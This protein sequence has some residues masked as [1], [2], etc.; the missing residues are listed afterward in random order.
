MPG[1]F[2][3]LNGGQ[4]ADPFSSIPNPNTSEQIA[5][6]LADKQ[7]ALALVALLGNRFLAQQEELEER[8]G[9]TDSNP[10]YYSSALSSGDDL[11]AK[12][13]EWEA[14]NQEMWAQLGTHVSRVPLL[15]IRFVVAH[16]ADYGLVRVLDYSQRQLSHRASLP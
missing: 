4:A 11:E 13:K 3:D 2:P 9:Q 14:E 16:F 7:K 10:Q 12:T 8:L 6:L 15:A 5:T 1:R